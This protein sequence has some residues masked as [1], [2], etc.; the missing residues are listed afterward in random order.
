MAYH[1]SLLCFSIFL[2]FTFTYTEGQEG[3][4]G[5]IVFGDSLLDV[6]N[7]NHLDL[8]LAKA[9]FPHNGVDFAGEKA[10]GRFS[11]GKNAADF[12]AE[13]LGLPT[14]PP[15][16]SIKTASNKTKVVL[17]GGGIS[18]ASGGAGILNETNKIFRQ[19]ISFNEQIE[20]YSRIHGGLM[21]QLG[22]VA[23][24][25]YLAKS[26][27]LISM[28]SND[29][30]GFFDPNSKLREEYTPQQYINTLMLTLRGQLKRTYDLGAR[31]FAVIGVGLIGCCP[32]LRSKNET[33]GC[34]NVA[35]FWSVKYNEGVKSLLQELK[36]ELKDINYS[37]FFTYDIIVDFVRQPALYGFSE[38]KTA[39]C[40]RGKFNAEVPCLP[41]ARYCKN[42]RIYLFWD[43]Y[44]PT[45]AAAQ[46]VIDRFFNGTQQ[47]VH[48]INV[49]Q[50]L[51]M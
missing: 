34:N 14:S 11:N 45:E 35:N 43:L 9:N 6:G 23:A 49:K 25:S 36:A 39:C 29:I 17:E 51:A 7:N 5:V 26:I 10:T 40:G 42:R 4:P 44:H 37:I 2:F 19:S 31:K 28:G 32:S 1:I 12:L 47:Y 24:K 21:Q 15:Y 48:P 16:L 41:I 13:K 30:L 22:T 27:F 3:I 38:V 33:G 18:F 8:S 20:Y 50:L 46:I